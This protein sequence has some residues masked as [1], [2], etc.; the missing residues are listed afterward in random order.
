MSLVDISYWLFFFL[1]IIAI[2][3]G[4]WKI[5]EK[6]GEA[7]WKA[8]VPVYNYMVLLRILG[9]PKWWLIW[10]F[11]P[12][13]NLVIPILLAVEICKSFGKTSLGAHT[14]AMLFPYIYLPY[15]G[16]HKDI[17]Y[18]GHS[19][20]VYSGVKRG[21]GREW[22]DAI[23][24]AL[25]A[26][27]F[28]RIFWIEAYKIPTSSME[29]TLLV[30]DHLFVSKFHYGARV[31]I[32]PIAFPLA[33]HTLP[34]LGTKAYIDLIQL[35]YFR[36]P[37]MEE[38]E[39]GDI[40]VFNF[41]EGDTVYIADQ[42]NSYYLLKKRQHIPDDQ[43]IVRPLDKKENYVKRCVAGPGD[44][45]RIVSGQLYINEERAENPPRMQF[46]YTIQSTE[47]LGQDFLKTYQIPPTDISRIPESKNHKGHLYTVEL[48]EEKYD[49]I[50]TLPHIK[51]IMKKGDESGDITSDLFPGQ[52]QSF[53]YNLDYYGPL[54]IP[55]EGETVKLNKK[56]LPIYKRLI[57]TYE[58]NDLEIRGGKLY[59]NGEQTTEYTFRQ[60]YYFMMGDNRHNSQDSRFWGFVPEDHIVGKAWFIWLSL[61]TDYNFWELHKK[62]RWERIFQVVR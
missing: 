21:Q 51:D 57:K 41:P 37:G 17:K 50:K 43:I 5:F 46:N 42:Q 3:A 24:F 2:H 20:E 9:K 16:F 44:T 15:L 11:I 30:G 47:S 62:V 14:L 33:H 23:I 19:S 38:V 7:G 27:T 29:S 55:K 26:A 56:N 25:V 45:L 8:I 28:I 58:H 36:L 12:I 1:S 22:A 10:I 40:V 18:L 60:N 54:V 35:P 61:N 59:I 31:P 52:P 13:V 4:L 48:S 39:R 6:A 34:V 32:T 53:P 49:K